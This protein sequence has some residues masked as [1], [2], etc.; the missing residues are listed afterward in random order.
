MDGQPVE[1]ERQDARRQ[2]LADAPKDVGHDEG[3]VGVAD[4][5]EDFGYD[6]ARGCGDDDRDDGQEERGGGVLQTGLVA[7]HDDEGHADAGGHGEEGV[8][9]PEGPCDVYYPCSPGGAAEDH[10]VDNG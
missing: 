8:N 4:V 2:S 9:P 7:V 6:A 5:G 10:H 3:G 1:V